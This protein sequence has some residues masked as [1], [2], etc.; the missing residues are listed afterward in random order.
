MVKGD[1][2]R[3]A[4]LVAG[5]QHPAVMFEFGVGELALLRLDARP[6][7]REAIGVEAERRQQ[8]NIGRVAMIMVAGIPGRLDENRPGQMLQDPELRC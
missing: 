3:D 2:R 7:D 6:F 4:V 1:D 5:R 8:G